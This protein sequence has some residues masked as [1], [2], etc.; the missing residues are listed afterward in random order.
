MRLAALGALSGRDDGDEIITR[1]L[2]SDDL[3]ERGTAVGLL[4]ER[5]RPDR[6]ALLAAAY[7]AS[8]GTEWIEIREAIADAVAE[9]EEA[10][11]LLQRMTGDEAASVRLKAHLALRTLGDVLDLEELETEPSPL[12][13]RRVETNPLVVLETNKGEIG[14]RCFTADAPLHVASFVDLARSGHYDGLIWHRVVPNFVIQGGDPRGDGWGGAGYTLRDEI[15][16]RLYGRGAV[17]MPKAGKDTGGGQIFITHVPT[18]H[19]DGNYTVF[20]YVE[21]GME[22]VDRIE[23]GDEIVAARVLD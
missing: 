16:T 7:D 17:G 2:R 11:S 18:P 14:I 5:D 9:S 8:P 19:L 21:R 1:F 22:V 6:V 4:V 12:L 3:A 10:R 13:D 23:V 15:N 20:G